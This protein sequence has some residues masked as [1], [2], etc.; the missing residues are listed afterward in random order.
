MKIIQSLFLS[1]C[2]CAFCVTE[3][4]AQKESAN[5]V[6]GLGSGLQFM[7]DNSIEQYASSVSSREG[8][9]SISDPA[10]GELLF[11]T[12]GSKIW[13][14]SHAVMANGNG[15]SGDYSSSQSAVIVPKPGDKARYYVFAADFLGGNKGYTYSIVNIAA[16]LGL[17]AVE[18]ATKNTLLFQNNT[19]KITVAKHCNGQDFWLILRESNGNTFWVYLIDEGGIQPPQKFSLGSSIAQDTWNEVG[20]LEMS[21]N[22][23]LLAHTIGPTFAGGPSSVEVFSFDNATG[24]ITGLTVS[25]PG[26]NFAYGVEFSLDGKLL[27]ISNNH[28]SGNARVFQYNIGLGNAQAILNSQTL[29]MASDSYDYGAMQI[30]P[31]GKIYVAK[32]FG[33][34]NGS[35][36]LDIIHSPSTPGTGCGYQENGLKLL[37]GKSLIGL[38]NFPNY[39]FTAKPKITAQK[40]CTTRAFDFKVENAESTASVTWNFGDPGSGATNTSQFLQPSHTFSDTGFFTVK[41]VF[42]SAC[43]ADTAILSLHIRGYKPIADVSFCKGEQVTL[44]GP[45]PT[46]KW[47]GITTSGTYM[48]NQP[49]SVQYQFVDFYGCLVTN[50]VQVKEIQPIT[51]SQQISMCAGDT[52]WVFNQPVVAAGVFSMMYD[53]ANGCDSIHAVSVT[54][55]FFAPAAR[56]ATI[57]PGGSV[58]FGGVAYT[59]QGMFFDTLPATVGCDTALVVSIFVQPLVAVSQMATIC[60]GNSVAFGGVVYSQ[61]GIFSDTLPAATGGCDTVLTV[62]ILQNTDTLFVPEKHSIC[63]GDTLVAHGAKLTQAGI[64]NFQE[65][66]LAACVLVYRVKLELVAAPDFAVDIDPGGCNGKPIGS[67]QIQNPQPGWQ[68]RLGGGNW[69]GSTSFD[70]LP[71]GRY[72][73]SVRNAQGCESSDTVQVPEALPF[74]LKI[75]LDTTLAECGVM[76]ATASHTSQFPLRYEW[77]PSKG[78]GCADC[79]TVELRPEQ[80]QVYQLLAVDSAGCRAVAEVAAPG[81]EIYHIYVPNV[82]SPND[83]GENDRFTLYGSRCA[84]LI[85]QL[86][87]YDRWGGQVFY[88]E[89]LPLGDE[90]KGWDGYAR[91]Q[92]ATPG[93]FTWW[94]EV[95]LHSGQRVL[96]KGSVTVV[97]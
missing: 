26:M 24:T 65:P 78:L 41:T 59:Q 17:G 11:Y 69:S 55:Q 44:V 12:D 57:C 27:Y 58:T 53:A 70:Q 7:P 9:S 19:E 60:P 32:E 68:A 63:T 39:L 31:N 79:P 81:G 75:R 28:I 16:N 37:V 82:F 45:S 93:V 64:Y 4:L 88:K 21:S 73:L 5:W 49:G 34:D 3:S 62:I 38:P 92:L 91:S 6:F 61:P 76:T 47:N 77:Q 71:A 96:L 35:D 50:F 20:Y 89:N 30:A 42:L 80:G 94:A 72:A 66:S 10:T 95:E 85:R 46:T 84:Q 56:S 29:L 40:N 33:Y 18:G 14:H 51:T 97:L 1:F 54:Q 8:V 83:D 36:Y 43:G 15:L 48:V 52:V 67:I 90:P 25:I 22:Q 23:K 86:S 13:D 2:L 74:L 87:I